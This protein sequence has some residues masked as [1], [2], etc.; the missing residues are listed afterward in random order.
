MLKQPCRRC[1]F[2]K[3]M[4]YLNAERAREIALNAASWDGV[5]WWCHETVDYSD[6][7]R[8]TAPSQ[9]CAGSAIFSEKH[10]VATQALRIAGR[11]G[12]YDPSAMKG[13]E[14]VYD[15][16]E[17]MVDGHLADR[18]TGGGKK[19]ACGGTENHPAERSEDS[20]P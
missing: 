19:A 20:D 16:V 8:S 10:G 15:S 18:N 12:L 2:L 1:P 17:E 6:D 5:A 9:H 3:S 7:Q 13:V 4:G 14:L 11:L